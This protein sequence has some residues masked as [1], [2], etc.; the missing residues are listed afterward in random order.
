MS[1][2][3]N[4][5]EQSQSVINQES[6]VISNTVPDHHSIFSRGVVGAFA[7][8]SI[9]L[10]IGFGLQVIVARVL[11]P[12]EL[13][14]YV[15]ALTIVNLLV[16]LALAG[17]ETALLRFLPVYLVHRRPQYARGL[18]Q[19]T[20]RLVFVT[21]CLATGILLASG[22]LLA[23]KI[24][25]TTG[26]T[27]Y[28]AA[29]LVPLF[30]LAVIRQTVLRALKRVF[31]AEIPD[32][33]LRPALLAI[34][35]L[36]WYW[37]SGEKLTSERM[38]WFQTAAAFVALIFG[39]MLLARC[40]PSEMRIAEPAHEIRLWFSVTWPLFLIGVAQLVMK[41]AD[42]LMLG[43][44]RGATETGIYSVMLRISDFAM[45]GLVTAN[46]IAA[47]MIAELHALGDRQALQKMI[48]FAAR[49]TFTFTVLVT[50][51]I[52]YFGEY[53]IA[54]FGNEFLA[55][56]QALTILLIGQAANAFT[57]PV[58]FLMSMTGHHYY[59]ALIVGV[60]MLVN[61]AMNYT[62]IPPFGIEGAAIAST[63]SLIL[64]NVWM[65][66]YVRYKLGLRSMVI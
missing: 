50:I 47:P 29:L 43:M 8:K 17:T 23:E 5:A 13:G 49:L 62:L 64:W 18:L 11:G 15:Y 58:G 24:G 34:T 12:Y 22:A 40:L 28:V 41:Q 59:A 14:V 39:Y 46:A 16:L 42:I 4:G 30:S 37:W 57:G 25:A 44:L 56:R 65:L 53:L 63:V 52:Y 19:N 54:V 7:G 60:T 9:A 51:M 33:M 36:A 2:R 26:T 66:V 21:S 3:E 10:G 20:T 38:M 55:G 27:F 31:L 32:A 6:T 35:V 1:M 45:F 61:L 48:T